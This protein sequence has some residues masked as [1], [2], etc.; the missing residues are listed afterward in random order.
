MK[1]GAHQNGRAVCLHEDLASLEGQSRSRDCPSRP[2]LSPVVHDAVRCVPAPQGVERLV[3]GRA[4][5]ERRRPRGRGVR[6]PGAGPQRPPPA[7]LGGGVGL[8]VSRELPAPEPAHDRGP[9]Q[10][11]VGRRRGRVGRLVELRFRGRVDGAV[12]QREGERQPV[13]GVERRRRLGYQQIGRRG[14]CACG[15]SSEATIGSEA[16]AY[17]AARPG[18]QPSARAASVTDASTA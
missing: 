13:R 1:I 7:A 12:G 17:Q 18:V 5:R 2:S 6:V 14:V 3:P 4:Q 16:S 8:R 10:R 11:N 15:R 9:R